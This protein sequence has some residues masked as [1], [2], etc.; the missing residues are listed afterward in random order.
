MGSR[1]PHVGAPLHESMRRSTVG[2]TL[3]GGSLL[4]EGAQYSSSVAAA[5][6]LQGTV[7]EWADGKHCTLIE[8]AWLNG[9][10]GYAGRYP[11]GS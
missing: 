11:V 7:I 1:S 3:K 8:L 10:S 2:R 4:S 5:R 9:L 6:P